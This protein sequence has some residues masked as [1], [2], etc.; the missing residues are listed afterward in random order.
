LDSGTKTIQ[1]ESKKMKD[2]EMPAPKN[3]S[4]T[5][6]DLPILDKHNLPV[7][8]AYLTS[9][10]ISGLVSSIQK[11][12]VLPGNQLICLNCLVTIELK[13]QTDGHEGGAISA[14][15][16][17]WRESAKGHNINAR[18]FREAV[19]GLAKKEMV[20]QFG[21]VYRSVPKDTENGTIG[22]VPN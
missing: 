8:G 6:V 15:Y 4:I 16:D 21:D 18:R 14:N 11:R 7:K 3:F 20:K 5:Q 17:E 22:T 1:F 13:K 2:A 19:E 9:V 12:T 10:D